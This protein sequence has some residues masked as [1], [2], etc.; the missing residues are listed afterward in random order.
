M[1]HKLAVNVLTL[2]WLGALTRYA[3][4]ATFFEEV[5]L[6]DYASL[7]T[8]AVG[9]LLGGGCKTLYT[10]ATDG[11][12][13]FQILKESRNDMVISFLAGGF[14]YLVMIMLES[15]WPGMVTREIRFAGVLI[16]G[17]AGTAVFTWTTRLARARLDRAAEDL[18]AGKP[19][20]PPTS[21]TVPLEGKP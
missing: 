6:A 19:L 14:V 9:G 8:A 13:V 11:R 4:A 20:E 17:W 3:Y 2:L 16:A 12:A 15:K 10:L 1:K 5:L 21:A 7:L 18:R